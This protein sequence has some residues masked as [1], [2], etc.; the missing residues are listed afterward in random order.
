MAKYEP[1]NYN[2]NLLGENYFVYDTTNKENTICLFIK[3]LP[4]ASRCPNCGVPSREVAATYHR[5]LQDTPIHNENTIL[6]VDIYKYRCNNSKCSQKIFVEELPFASAYQR[7]T[8]ALNMFILGV[9]IYLSNEGA[10]NVLKLL[11]TNISNDSIQKLY[12][13]LE[14]VDDPNVKAVGI[15]DI[16]LRKGQSYATAVYDLKDHHLMALLRGRDVSSI[17]GWLE[18]HSKI[19]FVARDR[20]SAYAKAISEALPKC[21]QVADRFHLLQNLIDK[22]RDILKQN[23]P[24]TVFIKA[25][26]VLKHP[27]KKIWI[28]QPCPSGLLEHIDYD[29]S[30]PINDKGEQIVFDN[31]SRKLKSRQYKCQA[32]RRHSKQIKIIKIKQDYKLTA[33]SVGQAASK[34]NLSRATVIKYLKMTQFE[35]E[36]MNKPK[37][38]KKRKTI[39][40]DYSNIIY[41][42]MS[43]GLTDNV[44][45]YYVLSRGYN[46]NKNSLWDYITKISQ[47]N[48]PGRPSAGSIQGSKLCYPLG[49][50]C[51]KRNKLIK[52]ILTI[53]RES[54]K[55]IKDNRRLSVLKLSYPVIAQ[56]QKIFKEFHEV[57]MGNNPK[58]LGNFLSTYKN[59]M[60][61]GFCETIKKDIAP[62]KSA[63]SLDINSGFV[64]GNNNKL[65]LIKR[66]VYG[67]S[68][69][70]NFAK[71][72][73]LAFLAS[74][75]KFQ[76]EQL[77]TKKH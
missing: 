62:V 34:Y 54:S 41:K 31:K 29:N 25:D 37:N 51:I 39:M 75:D 57:L 66:I 71:K 49:V 23:L 52:D 26:R 64:E 30:I 60:I 32:T 50:V 35:I 68:G 12:D 16:A 22:L 18:Q 69:L 40:D 76:L 5:I 28:E 48:F 53:N 65:K 1:I 45:Y 10:S 8:D 73:Q 56:V 4:H 58:L 21:T 42:M 2:I 67:R 63:I 61:S 33:A 24:S 77:K 3:S 27:P 14:F 47:N 74:Q 43:D 13:Q 7:R 38:Y 15:D 20:A 11:G 36:E 19:K 9:S 46:H 6:D 17:K 55:Y 72:C 70:V 44:I 59:S